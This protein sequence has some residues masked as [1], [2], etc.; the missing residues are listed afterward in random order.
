VK[1]KKAGQRLDFKIKRGD[2]VV[3]GLLKLADYNAFDRNRFRQNIQPFGQGNLKNLNPEV[4]E[5]AERLKLHLERKRLLE[6]QGELEGRKDL[7]DKE[8]QNEIKK[9]Q[10][11]QLELRKPPLADPKQK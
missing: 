3:E 1:K 10:Q 11:M 6:D 9:L 5:Q 2:E 8:L 7:L 4:E